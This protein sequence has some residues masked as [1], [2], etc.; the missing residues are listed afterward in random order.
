MVRHERY[1]WCSSW[2]KGWYVLSSFPFI[3]HRRAQMKPEQGYGEAEWRGKVIINWASLIQLLEGQHVWKGWDVSFDLNKMLGHSSVEMFHSCLLNQIK[4]LS[5]GETLWWRAWEGAAAAYSSSTCLPQGWERGFCQ[6]W[7]LQCIDEWRWISPYILENNERPQSVCCPK[8]VYV[9]LLWTALWREKR[10]WKCFNGLV[11][12]GKGA[13]VTSHREVC[14]CSRLFVSVLP[15]VS[16]VNDPLQ[17][18]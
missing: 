15:V 10:L 14:A 5:F 12:K 1:S 8:G 17:A 4:T 13:D 11:F 7:S 6:C 18:N 3:R 16:L 2:R 9:L